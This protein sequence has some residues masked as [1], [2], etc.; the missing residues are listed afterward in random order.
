MKYY[1]KINCRLCNSKKLKKVLELTPTP[2]ADSYVEKKHLKFKQKTIPLTI[3]LCKVCGN[4][5]LSH[6]ISAKEVYLNYIYETQF[7]IVP[8]ALLRGL[9]DF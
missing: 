5:Q 3:M 1:K 2:P 8:L 9:L 4:S 6:V 7:Q